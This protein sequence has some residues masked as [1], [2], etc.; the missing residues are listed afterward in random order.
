MSLPDKKG[1]GPYSNS[2]FLMKYASLGMQLLVSL[3]L[4]V[5]LGLKAD[6]WLKISF[7]LLGW[8]MP[9][10]VLLVILY[11]VVKDTSPKK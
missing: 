7:P 4:A 11:K 2:R 8:L 5:F 10:L 3:G 1:E 6:G 9:L